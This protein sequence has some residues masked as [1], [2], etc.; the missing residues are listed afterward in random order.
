MDI[1]CQL[2]SFIYFLFI[3]GNVYVAD[4]E[5]N[6]IRKVIS[7]SPTSMPSESP[8][9]VSVTDSTSVPT[10]PLANQPTSMPTCQPTGQPSSQPTVQPSAQPT[11]EPSAQ[12]SS[13][14]TAQPTMEPSVQPTAQPTAQPTSEP[15]SSTTSTASNSTIISTVAGTGEYGY[16][17]DDSD[18]TSATLSSPAG[19][20]VD[21]VGNVYFADT[22]IHRVRKITVS[23]GIISTY[24]GTGSGSYSGDGGAATSAALYWPNGLCMD[25]AGI[26]T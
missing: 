3:T 15:S 23:T 5:N 19:I 18:A 20:A 17:G 25:S 6:R 4:T 8:V 22:S 10:S 21:S 12:P 7:Y 9:Q 26:N 1:N 14:P 16:S 2:L 13:Q 11:V 24:V